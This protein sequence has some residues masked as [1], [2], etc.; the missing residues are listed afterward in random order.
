MTNLKV[1]PSSG[2]KREFKGEDFSGQ[3]L[4]GQDMRFGKYI[5]CSF[6]D[7][8]MKLVNCEG[9]DFTNSTFRRTDLYRA[10]WKD[11]KLAGIVFEPKDCY[12]I[13]FTFSC[14]T[15]QNVQ[16]GRLWWF[17]WA[18]MLSEMYPTA[19]PGT[20]ED[21]RSKII[22]LIGA[23]RYTKLKQLFNRREF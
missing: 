5:G 22:A 19:G 18:L 1:M 17:S 12:G 21:L 8:D 13:T 20:T 10:N 23:E 6:D 11:C 7:A 14:S 16:I 4:T 3:D 2:N 9:S 15:F